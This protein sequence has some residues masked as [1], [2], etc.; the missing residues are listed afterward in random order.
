MSPEQPQSIEQTHPFYYEASKF[1]NEQLSGLAYFAIQEIIFNATDEDLSA[2]RFQLQQLWHVAA[3]GAAPS[4][5]VQEQIHQELSKGKIVELP[6]QLVNDLSLRREQQIKLG[7]WVERHHRP[8][9]E[10]PKV[11]PDQKSPLYQRKPKKR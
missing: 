3:L 1:S 5:N 8:G 4:E 9:S 11:P 2:Y 10:I 6:D 7:S